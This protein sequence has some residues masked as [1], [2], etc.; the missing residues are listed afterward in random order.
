MTCEDMV[1]AR[2]GDAFVRLRDVGY[3]ELSTFEIRNYSYANG[4]P[5]ITMGV[6]RQVGSNVVE[7]MDGVMAAVQR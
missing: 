5:N 1:I 3:A 4:R 6:R 2:R 7:V